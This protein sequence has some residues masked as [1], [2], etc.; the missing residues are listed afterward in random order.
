MQ[1]IVV[2]LFCTLLQSG[3][4]D[5]PYNVANE[6]QAICHAVATGVIASMHPKDLEISRSFETLQLM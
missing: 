6:Y 1:V 4:A 3:G 2:A 5:G